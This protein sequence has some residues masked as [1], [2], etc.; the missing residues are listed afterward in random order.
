MKIKMQQIYTWECPECG[1]QYTSSKP[2]SFYC[3]HCWDG[4]DTLG[5]IVLEEL[6]SP[7]EKPPEKNRPF[8]N[9]FE[10]C[11]LGRKQPDWDKIH[12][13]VEDMLDNLVKIEDEI[14]VLR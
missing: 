14:E 5:D 9:C 3:P 11:P 1:E 7:G 4:L 6:Y 8:Q 10:D 2:E 13:Y 12:Q